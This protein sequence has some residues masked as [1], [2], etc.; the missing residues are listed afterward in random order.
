MRNRFK[1]GMCICVHTYTC[2][3]VH[4]CTCVCV[5]ALES[6]RET[7][8]DREMKDLQGEEEHRSA[9]RGSSQPGWSF[10]ARQEAPHR[11]RLRRDS[12]HR[13]GACMASSGDPTP[14]P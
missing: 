5:C 8:R 13:E 9:L 2:M 7:D 1:S 14:T 10:G 11:G 12:G 3:C 4:M 6:E